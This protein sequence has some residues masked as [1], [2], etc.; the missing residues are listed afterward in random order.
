LELALREQ[1]RG[2]RLSSKRFL[3]IRVVCVTLL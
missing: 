1:E 2:Q 3:K